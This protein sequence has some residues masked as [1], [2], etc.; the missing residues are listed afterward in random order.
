MWEA[1][2]AFLKSLTVYTIVYPNELAVR[3]RGG[4]WHSDL[5]AGFYWQWPIY[6][7]IWKVTAVAQVKEIPIQSINN[8][9]VSGVIEYKITNAHKA[10]FA[11]ED[12]DEKMRTEVMVSVANF[13]LDTD[14][15]VPIDELETF[16]KEDLKYLSSKYGIKL[17]NY[18]AI[19]CG[20]HKV[21][22]F[23]TTETLDISD[24]KD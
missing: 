10:L 22:R 14:K 17:T 23:I 8:F 16:V 2:L 19:N 9:M 24:R 18:S 3:T 13:L 11:V 4:I 6:D 15:A 7:S 21:Y 20:S 5:D 12:F 1:I